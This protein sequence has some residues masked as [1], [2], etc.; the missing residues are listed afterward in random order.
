MSQ[1]RLEWVRVHLPTFNWMKM[2]DAMQYILVQ[3]FGLFLLKFHSEFMRIYY[4]KHNNFPCGW[5]RVADN[6]YGRISLGE[7]QSDQVVCLPWR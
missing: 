7:R 2:K 6:D 5:V 1:V 4:I 3:Y